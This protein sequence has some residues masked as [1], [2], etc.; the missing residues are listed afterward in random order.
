MTANELL[1][2]LRRLGVTVVPNRGKGGHVRVERNG[3]VSHVPSGSGESKIGLV[4][5]V[6][7]QLG[8]TMRDLQ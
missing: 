4:H 2:K 1:R 5:G 6:L 7:R 3:R 8:L